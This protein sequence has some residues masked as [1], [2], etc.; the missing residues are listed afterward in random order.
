MT[1]PSVPIVAMNANASGMPPKFAATPEK[2][3]SA[4][5]TQRGAPGEARRVGDQEPEQA[6]EERRDEADLDARPV[7]ASGT[8]RGTGRA[9]FESV[10]PPSTL[11]N[12]PTITSAAG[13]SRNATA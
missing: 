4:E 3:E 9:M 8:A 10:Q 11:L 5:R 6:A 2:V 13:T 12:A 1:I 7:V